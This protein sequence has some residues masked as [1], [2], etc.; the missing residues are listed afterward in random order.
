MGG[1]YNVK[2]IHVLEVGRLMA[3]LAKERGWDEEKQKEMFM[4]GYV[5]DVGYE[6]SETGADHA[7]L[8]GELLK[9]QGYK[10]WKEVYYH[11]LYDAWYQ[12]EELDILN[13][14]DLT[15]NT[16]GENIGVE[17]RLENIA[18]RH[19]TDSQVYIQTRK[20]AESLGLI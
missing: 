13:I 14:A 7:K 3:Q 9:S 18:N 10:Y 17:K 11:G 16:N 1:L 6:F 8:G 4:L 19:G 20:L 2:Q 15:I 5:H 12:S